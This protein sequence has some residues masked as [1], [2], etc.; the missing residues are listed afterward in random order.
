MRK[1]SL[2]AAALMLT[3]AGCSAPGGQ[4]GAAPDGAAEAADSIRV[5]IPA[6]ASALAIGS[7]LHDAGLVR[8][9]RGFALYVRLRGAQSDLK[10]GQYGIPAAAGWDDILE[11]LR[12]GQVLTEAVTIPEGLTLRE[13]AP[14]LA[15][16]SGVTADSVLALARSPD[17]TSRLGVPGPTLEGYLLPETYRFAE[18]VDPETVLR[19]MATAYLD[20]WT[21]E[22]RALADSLGLDERELVTLASI[23]EEEARR[24]EERS[25]IASVYLNRLRIGMLLQADPTVQY[26]LGAPRARLLYRDIDSVADNPYNTYT[27]PGLPPGPISS[28]G[29]ATLDA[30]LRPEQADFLYFVARPDG[31]H[32]F[33]RTSR[34][35][36][37]AKNRIRREG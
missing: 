26:A 23:V 33:T 30:T 10:S 22:R 5:N 17:L 15:E 6:G 28:P 31:S 35:H 20:F 16:V 36:I 9:A 13:I 37:N 25:L 32:V 7:A 2:C 21:P 4:A 27:N 19:A 14:R 8:T 24:P 29:S 34:E 11:Q 18:G 3:L 1:S 12:R